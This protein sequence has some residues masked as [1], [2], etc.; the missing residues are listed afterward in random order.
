VEVILLRGAEEDLWSAW[1]RYELIQSGL[2]DGFEAEVQRTLA[3]IADYPESAPLYAGKFRRRQLRLLQVLRIG[4][5]CD[6]ST[7]RQEGS[8][9]REA[10]LRTPFAPS[11]R[12]P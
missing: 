5:V 9:V 12:F 8:L 11:C 6:L 3:Q 7:A 4:A 1:E 10:V 2:G